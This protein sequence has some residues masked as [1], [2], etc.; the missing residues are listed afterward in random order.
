MMRKFNYFALA[1]CLLCLGC[2]ASKV[3][4]KTTDTLTAAALQP[5]GRYALDQKQ[6]LELI[7]SA[8]HFGFSFQGTQCRVFASLSGNE[9][10][11]LQYELDGVYQKRIRIAAD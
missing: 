5:F 10:N 9:H 1:V 4:S 2:T 7:S 6:H 11:Y 3:A 8:V